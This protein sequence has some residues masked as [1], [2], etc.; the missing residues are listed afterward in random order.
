ME[1]LLPLG[2]T[3]V[4]NCLLLAVL[5]RVSVWRGLQIWLPKLVTAAVMLAF[6]FFVVK[7]FVVEGF[8]QTS[9]AMAPTLLGTHSPGTCPHCGGPTTVSVDPQL[10]PR[11]SMDHLGMCSACQQPGEARIE[12]RI[13]TTAADRYVVCKFLPPARWDVVAVHSP[14]PARLLMTRRVIGLPGEEVV[15]RDGGIWIDG[16]KQEQPADIAELTF[17]PVDGMPDGFGSPARPLQLGPDEYFVLG[18]FSR[19]SLDSRSWGPVP[20][21]DITGVVS[22][23]YFP[24]YRVRLLK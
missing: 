12:P 16:T 3:A 11:E 17:A 1:F 22:L 10:P 18:D 4:A 2:V 19:R 7:P 24:L 6:L 21:T 20:R 5:F 14:T 9:H 23:I 13:L 8:I 15:I